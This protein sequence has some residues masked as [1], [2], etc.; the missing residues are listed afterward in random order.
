MVFLLGECCSLVESLMP[1]KTKRKPDF[2]IS[3]LNKRTEERGAVGAGWL[4][5]N[6]TISIVLDPFVTLT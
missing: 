3:A 6:G 1:E 5:E 4:N 2:K